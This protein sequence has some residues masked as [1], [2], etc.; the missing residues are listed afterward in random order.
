M[1]DECVLLSM[2]VTVLL[3]ML[4]NTMYAE[5]LNKFNSI[6]YYPLVTI[7]PCYGHPFLFLWY[8]TSNEKHHASHMVLLSY[9]SVKAPV[10]GTLNSAISQT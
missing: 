9:S 2:H 10:F 5:K 6:Q 4:C 3:I 8:T 1:P 7:R